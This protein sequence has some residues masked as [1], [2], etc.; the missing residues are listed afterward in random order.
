MARK[1]GIETQKIQSVLKD[2]RIDPKTKKEMI[3]YSLLLVGD[4]GKTMMV[5]GVRASVIDGT[6]EK[7]CYIRPAKTA[8]ELSKSRW[9]IV[10]CNGVKQAQK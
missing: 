4:V 9:I 1:F 10:A 7:G 8:A 5:T 2:V 3:F 6:P